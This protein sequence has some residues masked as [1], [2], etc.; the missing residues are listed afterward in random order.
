MENNIKLREALVNDP[1]KFIEVFSMIGRYSL[2]EVEQERIDDTEKAWGAVNCISSILDASIE[3]SG[4]TDEHLVQLF[5]VIREK[6]KDEYLYEKI[7][8]LLD[9]LLRFILVAKNFN[10]E[11][12]QLVEAF[13]DIEKTLH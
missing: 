13:R 9:D 3:L 4:D 6:T 10:G 5:R 11:A 7:D 2:G 12:W 1:S 8:S